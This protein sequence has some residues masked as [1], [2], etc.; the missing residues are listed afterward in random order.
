M[1]NATITIYNSIV[2]MKNIFAEGFKITDLCTGKSV[3]MYEFMHETPYESGL[4]S[5]TIYDLCKFLRE[6][7]NRLTSFTD[8][9][10]FCTVL[11]LGTFSDDEIYHA[12]YLPSTA[13]CMETYKKIEKKLR[14]KQ[15]I[16]VNFSLGNNHMPDDPCDIMCYEIAVDL[17]T[18]K[19]IC[20]KYWDTEGI[21]CIERY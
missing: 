21:Q 20:C 12:F 2:A 14:R 10:A 7:Y 3:N 9:V 8:K 5:L 16:S 13:K 11:S 4:N 15:R 6:K 17:F 1:S 19:P 18:A